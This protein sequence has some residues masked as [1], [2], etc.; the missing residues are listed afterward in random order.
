MKDGMPMF[1]H[2]VFVYEKFD[3]VY[4]DFISHAKARIIYKG[5]TFAKRDDVVV[6]VIKLDE[7]MIIKGQSLR[8]LA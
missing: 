5:V 6:F 8:E 4:L 2:K 3:D 7:C 1:V